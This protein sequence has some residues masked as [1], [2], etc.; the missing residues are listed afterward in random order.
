MRTREGRRGLL[1]I[2]ILAAALLALFLLSF[3]LGRYGV[4]LGEVVKILLSRV[5]PIEQTWT[6][7]QAI[8]VLNVRLPRI[9]LAVLV[10]ACLS[11]AGAAYQV[12]P[13]R[14][15]SRTPW[16]RRIFW[17]PPPERALGRRWPFF[18][19]WAALA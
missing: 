7:T 17:A 15:C 10:G 2:C 9:L 14:P 6:D 13:T 16:P 3:V 8:A 4:P 1:F 19:G 5:F 12:P 11:A 18:L